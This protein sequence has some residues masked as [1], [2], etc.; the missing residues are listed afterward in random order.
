MRPIPA[1]LLLA[2][3]SGG[4]P[5][6]LDTGD[7]ADTGVPLCGRIRGTESILMYQEGGGTLRSPLDPPTATDISYGVAGPIGDDRTY[8]AV[9]TSR[10]MVSV[11][12]GCNWESQGAVADGRWRLR[13]AGTRVYAFDTAS[14]AGARSDDLGVTWSPFDA[15]AAFVGVPV[16]DPADPARIRGVQAG[17]VV[18]STDGGETWTAGAALPEGLGAALDA[19]L[20]ASDLD[21]IVVGGAGGAFRTTDGG[22]TWS[23]IVTDAAVTA[24]AIHPDDGAVLFAQTLDDA[25]V[26]TISRSADGGAV[27]ARQ[28]DS[29]QVALGDAPELWPVPG[30]PLQAL[31]AYGPVYNEDT[32]SDGVN[33]YVVTASEGTRTFY[34]GTWFHMHQIA[35][36][37]ERWIAAVDAAPAR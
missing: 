30:N 8:V 10:A 29:N 34:V 24:L 4:K 31:A 6:T 3:C 2:A 7:T 5:F 15:G 9:G 35:F 27:W 33:L 17:G 19:D 13:G 16:V 14:S 37:A 28:V 11:D 36:G 1:L 22:A 18:T 23:P 26:R 12:G 25:G 20:L 32:E 21:Q